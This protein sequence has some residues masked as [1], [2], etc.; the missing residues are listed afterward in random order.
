MFGIGFG[1][2]ML[3]AVVLLIAVGPDKMPK[4]M[5]AVG[6]T[7]KQVRQAS[8]E[9]RKQ[10][11]IDEIMRDDPVGLRQLKQDI[12]RAPAPRR[13]QT[14]SPED[15]ERER[16]PEGVDLHAERARVRREAQAEEQ[17]DDPAHASE[18][19]DADDGEPDA[20]GPPP[21]TVAAPRKP[22]ADATMPLGLEDLDAAKPG[23][24]IPP[25]AVPA[26]AVSAARKPRADATMPLE[27]EDLEAYVP[28]P[29]KPPE[30]PT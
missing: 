13:T 12:E 18:G 25:P 3:V 1:E 15:L 22:R 30:T 7:L 6:K 24:P 5:K 2:M 27:T 26:P 8:T 16:P 23:P 21:G 4:L 9:L 14:L 29:P 20:A 11:G 19:D 28:K 17:A 10:S